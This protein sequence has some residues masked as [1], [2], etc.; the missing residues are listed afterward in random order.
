MDLDA[1]ARTERLRHAP[2]TMP[3]LVMKTLSVSATAC[4]A[5]PTLLMARQ[6]RGSNDG[7]RIVFPGYAFSYC[8]LASCIRTP[9]AGRG[10]WR[11]HD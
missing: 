1:R 3:E 5:F 4:C 2:P 8:F 7:V 9:M 11:H 10:K 6:L